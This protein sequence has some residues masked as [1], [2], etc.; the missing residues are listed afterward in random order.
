MA[1]IPSLVRYWTQY[2]VGDP[3]MSTYTLQMYQDAINFACKDYAMKTGATYS[4]TTVTP[5]ANGFC[6][7]PSDYIRAQRVI[8]GGTELIESTFSFEDSKSNT[9]QT[10]TQSAA[11]FPPRRWVPWSGAKIKLTPIPSGTASATIIGFVQNPAALSCATSA[12]AAASVMTVGQS[13]YIVDPGSTSFTAVGASAN[14]TGVQFVASATAS[15]TGIVENVIDLRIPDSHNEFLKYAAAFW[16]L[17]LDGDGQDFKKADD[18]MA[19]FNALIGYSD[20]VLEAKMKVARTQ[21]ERE[22]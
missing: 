15:G 14:A 12:T 20:P 3:Q 10:Y 11:T 2:L 6:L 17:Q 9:W 21:P 1:Q 13:Y 5:D 19:K 4:E 22:M 8:Y 7:M 18:C 16:L